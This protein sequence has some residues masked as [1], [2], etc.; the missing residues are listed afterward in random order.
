MQ[1]LRRRIQQLSSVVRGEE[2]IFSPEAFFMETPFS[3]QLIFFLRG[4]ADSVKELMLEAGVFEG[5][6]LLNF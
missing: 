6:I 4:M 5:R 3:S 2:K 1:S